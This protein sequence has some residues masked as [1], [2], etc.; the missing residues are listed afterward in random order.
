[1]NSPRKRIGAFC[2]GKAPP[3]RLLVLFGPELRGQQRAARALSRCGDKTA[4]HRPPDVGHPDLPP[5]AEAQHAI[6]E[7]MDRPRRHT[8]FLSEG[9]EKP[10]RL[11]AAR[12]VRPSLWMK[13][14]ANYPASQLKLA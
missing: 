8:P 13:R 10:L 14:Q 4:N 9:I 1:M 12:T 7:K 11:P 2:S 5:P 3:R 6:A